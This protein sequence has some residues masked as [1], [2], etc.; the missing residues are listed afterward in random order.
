MKHIL[1]SIATGTMIV[2]GII[3]SHFGLIA[4]SIPTFLVISGVVAII[5]T[6]VY[7]MKKTVRTNNWWPVIVLVAL[8]LI[9]GSAA[10]ALWPYMQFGVMQ[11]VDFVYVLLAAALI[12]W[13]KGAS[14]QFRDSLFRAR[15]T[16]YN[17]TVGG[18]DGTN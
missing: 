14:R 3:L 4:G 17:P 8:C 12:Y 6:L 5:A 10:A 2:L 18:P 13:I 9:G 7:L 11:I 16:T 15:P 1:Q